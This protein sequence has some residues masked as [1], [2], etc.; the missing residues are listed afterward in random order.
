MKIRDIL[1]CMILGSL[2]LFTTSGIAKENTIKSVDIKKIRASNYSKFVEHAFW[3]SKEVID[4]KKI[5]KKL[6]PQDMQKFKDMI[7]IVLK[8][9][10][11]MSEKVIDSN[12]VAVENLRDANDYILLEYERNRRKI[13][14]QDGKALYIGIFPDEDLKIEESKLAQYVKAA[15]FQILN[16][17]KSDEN[18]KEPQIFV[19]KLDIG[20]SKLGR[21]YYRA[22]FPP[23]KFWYSSV[24]WWSDG[25]NILFLIGKGRFDGEDLSKRAGP[26]KN[27]N[28]PRKFKKGKSSNG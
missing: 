15:A 21:L 16:L 4:G 20:D 26:P 10:Y 28:A 9:E 1:V 19:S 25:K 11:L 23:P 14:I 6:I 3:H 5:S 13:R 27:V 7:R 24:R 12:A 22:S 18:G 17:P 8:S 2:A